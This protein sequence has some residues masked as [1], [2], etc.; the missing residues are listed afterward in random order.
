MISLPRDIENTLT[1]H[2]LRFHSQHGKRHHDRGVR[3]MTFCTGILSLLHERAY[4]LARPSS[5]YDTRSDTLFC[6]GSCVV[7][8][9]DVRLSLSLGS[10]CVVGQLV[11]IRRIQR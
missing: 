5:S 9:D 7:A 1:H 10:P 8:A 3:V 2:H 11:I 6:S 4:S